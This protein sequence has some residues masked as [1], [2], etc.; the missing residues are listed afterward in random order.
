MSNRIHATSITSVTGNARLQITDED[1]ID[2]R[3]RNSLVGLAVIS[4]LMVSIAHSPRAFAFSLSDLAGISN[5][6]AS[7]G[8]K[9]ALDKGT[10]IA[11]KL[12]G[13]P[14]GFWRNDLVRIALP[15]WISKAERGLKMPGRGKDIDALRLGINRAAEQAVPQSKILLTNAV[16]SMNIQDAKL[17]LTGG[18]NSV[19][20]FFRDKTQ[21]PL[22]EKFLPIV[23]NVTNKIGLATQYNDIASKIEKT[24]LIKLKPEQRKVETHVTN[25]AL[26][27]LYLM[28]GEEEKKIRKDPLGTGSDVLRRVFGALKR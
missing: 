9:A 6:D 4:A 16:K 5:T 14:D 11:V 22:T 27:G 23:T 7:A 20:N 13:K 17:I 26:N 19:T 2:L 10:D 3:R 15:D 1:I 24:G 28:I 12:L 21:S 8:V 18:D 25:K